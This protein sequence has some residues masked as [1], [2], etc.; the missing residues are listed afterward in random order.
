MCYVVA[1][2]AA[3]PHPGQMEVAERLRSLLDSD[4]FPSQISGRNSA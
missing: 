4:V 1:I 2:H 3:R